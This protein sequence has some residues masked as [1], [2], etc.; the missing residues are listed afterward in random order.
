[1]YTN[2][3]K[4]IDCIYDA[5]KILIK[6]Y[7]IQDRKIHAKFRKDVYPIILEKEDQSEAEL[8]ERSASLKRDNNIFSSEVDRPAMSM[9]KL[10]GYKS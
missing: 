5:W 1:M 3:R 9:P 7:Y 4:K 10:Y 2:Q 8:F 6:L